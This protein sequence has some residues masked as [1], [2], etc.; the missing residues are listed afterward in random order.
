ME[1]LEEFR[2]QSFKAA[3]QVDLARK[4]GLSYSDFEADWL[5]VVAILTEAQPLP[6]AKTI[7]NLEKRRVLK[8]TLSFTT[9]TGFLKNH[10]QHTLF[11]LCVNY[12]V[13]CM[14]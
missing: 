2:Q 3:L 11:V 6:P 13:C 10:P 8:K 5:E 14:E 7:Q 4:S 9:K 1:A 12:Y